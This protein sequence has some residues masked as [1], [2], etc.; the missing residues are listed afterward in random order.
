MES[1]CRRFCEEKRQRLAWLRDDVGCFKS[2]WRSLSPDRQQ[3]L[4]REKGEAILKGIVKQFFNE[5]EVTSTL[6]MDAL[7]CGCKQLE[8]LGKNR[9]GTIERSVPYPTQGRQCLLLTATIVL[10]LCVT[11]TSATACVSAEL[12]A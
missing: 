5:K 8:K 9:V 7:F 4:S 11:F 3:Q 1:I 10:F 12:P 2:W 6:V